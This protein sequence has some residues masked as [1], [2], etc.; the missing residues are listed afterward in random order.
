MFSKSEFEI[1]SFQEVLQLAPEQLI[2]RA[3]RNGWLI[4]FFAG[5]VWA[6]LR[7]CTKPEKFC[8]YFDHFQIG[9][10][11]GGMEMGFFFITG[12]QNLSS[13]PHELGHLIQ[14]AKFNCFKMIG[15][16]IGSALRYWKRRITKDYSI[17]YDS[18]WFEGQATALGNQY[19][20]R[21]FE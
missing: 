19:I 21:H 18:W 3:K 9:E 17:P 12:K 14:T 2:K 15:L 1:K 20:K 13:A 11:W 8:G 4:T 10:T 16:S 5:I 6:V 7:T